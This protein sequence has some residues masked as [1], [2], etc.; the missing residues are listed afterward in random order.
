MAIDKMVRS[1]LLTL[2]SADQQLVRSSLY[3]AHGPV[4]AAGHA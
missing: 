3:V 2:F 1:H 4:L